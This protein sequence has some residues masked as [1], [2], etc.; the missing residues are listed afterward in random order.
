MSDLQNMDHGCGR[1]GAGTDGAVL[2]V[3]GEFEP[4]RRL[5]VAESLLRSGTAVSDG[6]MTAV[7]FELCD[8]CMAPYSGTPIRHGAMLQLTEGIDQGIGPF[9]DR[10]GVFQATGEVPD[11]DEASTGAAWEWFE[12]VVGAEDIDDS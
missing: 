7:S 12:L 11:I 6:S 8:Q 1:C 5:T 4:V 9:F 2:W 3:V 10:F